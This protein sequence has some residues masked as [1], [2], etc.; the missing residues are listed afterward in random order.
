MTGPVVCLIACLPRRRE[1]GLMCR[2][3]GE[4]AACDQISIAGLWAARCGSRTCEWLGLGLGLICSEQL[5]DGSN[6]VREALNLV[7]PGTG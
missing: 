6:L 4:H 1:S 2:G 7:G 5:L 3:F